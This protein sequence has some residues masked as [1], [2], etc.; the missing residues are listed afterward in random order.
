MKNE[1][2][3]SWILNHLGEDRENYYNAVNPPMTLTSNFAFPN[4]ATMR[5]QLETE[6]QVPFYTRGYNPTVAILRKK[7]A[8]LE[9]TED[10]LVFAS[11]SAAVAAAVMSV[12]KAGDHVV[13]V[14]K[15]YSWTN[16]LISGYLSKY[17]VA[18]TFV[19]ASDENEV[20]KAVQ[21]N[22]RLIYLE[23]PNSMTF[24]MQNI[25]AITNYAKS[26]GITT[27]LDNS[28]SSPLNQKP[29]AMGV[30]IVVHSATKYLNGHSDVIAGVVASSSARISKMMAEEYM[31]LGAVIGAHDAWLIIRGMRTLELRVNRSST[32]A[33][34]I[35]EWLEQNSKIEKVYYPTLKTNSQYNL[36]VHQMKQGGGLLTI[37]LKAKDVSEVENFCNALRCF[38][39]ATSWGGH[40]SLILPVCA[41]RASASLSSQLPWNMVRMYIG[42]EDPQLL[43]RDLEQALSKMN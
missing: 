37:Q 5:K 23:S 24:E 8:A 33:Q 14:Q 6:L 40:E 27:I 12:V 29:A 41:L 43:I 36:A 4:V 19:D 20:F 32:S 28:Y 31:T 16:T 39:L 1:D 35:A 9:G 38:L 15:P 34:Q 26:A 42:L 11:G 25:T 2:N 17:G 21:K 3:I 30:D 10:T 18:S 22:T 7:I 13:C